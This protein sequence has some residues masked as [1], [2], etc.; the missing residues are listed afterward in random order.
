VTSPAPETPPTTEPRAPLREVIGLVLILV[1]ALALTTVA[2]FT[3][4]RL[5]FAVLGTFAVAVGALMA[6]GEA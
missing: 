3:D 5:G 4:P 1:G 6:F 2:F